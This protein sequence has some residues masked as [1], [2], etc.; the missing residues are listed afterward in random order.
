[1]R[2][3]SGLRPDLVAFALYRHR[4]H[5]CLPTTH[6]STPF[7][8]KNMHTMI[9]TTTTNNKKKNNNS[10]NNDNND[11]FFYDVRFCHYLCFTIL[12]CM[13]FLL[14]SDP[15]ESKVFQCRTS[16]PPF[17]AW[18]EK[19]WT[20]PARRFPSDGCQITSNQD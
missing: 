11:N 2:Q 1:M 4:A 9:G 12:R 20:N 3:R 10:N 8:E 18:L 15:R 13:R 6:K 16:A 5:C 7:G 14:F 17:V 19:I